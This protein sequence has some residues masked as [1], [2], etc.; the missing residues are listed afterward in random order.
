MDRWVDAYLDHLRVERGLVA[1]TVEAYAH[2]LARL[3]EHAVAEGVTSARQ[4]TVSTMAS[5]MVHL[6][7]RGVSARTAA[8]YLSAARGFTKFLV[9]ERVLKEDPCTLIDRP[10]LGKRLPQLLTPHEV[11]RLLEAPSEDKPRGRRD[12]AMLHLM[13]AAGLRVTGVLMTPLR[14]KAILYADM[15]NRNSKLSDGSICSQIACASSVT[16]CRPS[17]VLPPLS[18]ASHSF[19]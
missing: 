1:L 17:S 11:E 15:L 13:Y 2:D 5:F 19:L 9:R 6:G 18:R 3:V 4:L 8:R 12:R 16:T 7:G 10:K 14:K